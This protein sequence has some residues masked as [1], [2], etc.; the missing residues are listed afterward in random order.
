VQRLAAYGEPVEG[1]PFGRYRL[2]EVLGRG[3]MGEVWRLRRVQLPLRPRPIHRGR[4]RPAVCTIAAG[5]KRSARVV[6]ATLLLRWEPKTFGD[7]SIDSGQE[8]WTFNAFA[9]SAGSS[10]LETICPSSQSHHTN[11]RRSSNLM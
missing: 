10:E 2:I 4:Y 1:T 9:T 6:A 7:A 3:G 8:I 5:T 11:I